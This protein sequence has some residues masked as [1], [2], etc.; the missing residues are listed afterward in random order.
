MKKRIFGIL[1]AILMVATLVMGAIPA[2]ADENEITVRFHYHREDGDYEGWEMWLWDMDGITTLE[3]PYELVVDEANGDAVCEFTVKTGT[4]KIGYIVRKNGWEQKDVAH[5]QHINITGVLSGTVDFYVEAGVPTQPS[6]TPIPSRK[7]L[8]AKGNLKLGNDVTTGIVVT[9]AQYKISYEGNPELDVSMS[10]MPAYDI[11]TDT[12][13]ISNRDGEIPVVS[14]RKAGQHIYLVLGE[15]LDVCRGYNVVFEGREYDVTIPNRYSQEEFTKAFTYTGDDLGATYSKDKTT[16]RVW[17]PLALE[18]K[19]N[20]Y[21]NGNP[22]EEGMKFEDEIPYEVVS[23]TKDVN[24]TWVAT[25]EGDM[26]G[27]Y[28]TYAVTTDNDTDVQACDP[29][30]RTTGVNGKRAMIIDLAATNPEGWD[31]DTNPHKGQNFTDAIIYELHV[32]DISTDASSGIS[33]KNVGKFL[34]VIESGT[35]TE[36]GKATGLDHIVDLGVTHVHLLPVYDFGSVYE[37]KLTDPDYN[38]FNWGYDPMNYNVPEGSYSSDPYNGAVRVIEM[39]QMVK[40]L[41]DAGLSVIMDVVYNHVYDSGAFCFNKIVPGY[42]SRPDSNG[43]GCGNDTAS[44]L[45]MVSKYIIDSVNYWSTEYHIDGFRFD[46]VGLIDVDTINGLMNKVKETRDD[47]VFYGEGW[48]MGTNTKATLCTQTNSA[49]VP[50]FAFF[51]DTIRNLIKGGTFGGVNAGF[52]SGGGASTAELLAC[53]KGMPAWCKTPS[54][55]INYISCHDNNTLYDH[56]NMVTGSKVTSE[57]KVAMNKLGAAFYMTAQ[58]IPF[59]QAGEEILRSKPNG[60]YVTDEATGKTSYVLDGTFNENSYNASDEINSIKWSDLDDPAYQAVYQYYK[61]LIA[62]RKAHPALRLTTGEAVNSNVSEWATQT[63]NV[64]AYQVKGGME[65]ESADNL[66][67]VFNANQ[68]A[69][70][71]SLPAGNWKIYINGEYAGTNVLGTASGSVKVDA[72]SAMVLVQEAGDTLPPVKEPSNAWLI[73]CIV[74]ATLS[75]ATIVV[76]VVIVAKKKK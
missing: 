3:P 32:R 39:K 14:T 55:S 33:D 60:K 29:Y 1:M 45:P 54:Q 21:K 6:A 11:T 13:K 5:D 56:I 47:V 23:M 71:V 30:A 70:T 73:A 75:V 63:P 9:S 15:T 74:V 4:C 65:G 61:G 34:G 68:T 37:D 19:V 53:F 58:G 10:D 50:G 16:L 17:A 8:E 31:K 52:I 20:L 51:S 26:N 25:L 7:D 36:G 57:Q 46:L 28:Y 2:M 49:K 62:F 69:S 27:V 44:E 59:F 76:T 66:F 67:M 35:K 12:F 24:G 38:C 18:M 72:L 42:F 64:V 48:T 40:G 41:H 43:S 22:T